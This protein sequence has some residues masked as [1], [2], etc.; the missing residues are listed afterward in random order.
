V[1]GGA[2]SANIQF[3]E[4]SKEVVEDW[5]ALV[6]VFRLDTERKEQKGQLLTEILTA[7][8]TRGQKTKLRNEGWLDSIPQY[9][10]ETRDRILYS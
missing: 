3:D 8:L 9:P 5:V 1:I 7:G 2:V 6:N 4:K 10:D